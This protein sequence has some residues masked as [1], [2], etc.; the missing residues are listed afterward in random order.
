MVKIFDLQR[1]YEG[2]KDE[3]AGAFEQGV[4]KRRVHTG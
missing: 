2:L 3:L 1:E 4:Q